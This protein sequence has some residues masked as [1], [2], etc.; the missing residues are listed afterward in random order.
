MIRL[1]RPNGL[2]ATGLLVLVVLNLMVWQKERLRASGQTLFVA[3]TVHDPRAP[4]QGDFMAL[5]YDL[6]G[7]LAARLPDAGRLVVRV[8]ARGVAT[9]V[10]PYV[11]GEAL[12]AGERLL[13]F[14]RL[15][16]EVRLGPAAYF[17]QEGHAARYAAARYAELRVDDDGHALLVGLRDADLQP[18][19]GTEAASP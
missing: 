17:F 16:G 3:L 9:P 7:A 2:L 5:H 19:F 13:R 8:D 15:R 10:R 18:L 6:P 11:P 1:D 14:R 12:A 4:M